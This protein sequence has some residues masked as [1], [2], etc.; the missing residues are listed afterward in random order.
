MKKYADQDDDWDDG[1]RDLADD[2][3]AVRN[4]A[5]SVYSDYH[6]LSRRGWKNATSKDRQ[7]LKDIEDISRSAVNRVD[8]VLDGFAK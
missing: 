3:R 4:R 7:I 1:F 6:D 5:S 8:D 2:L